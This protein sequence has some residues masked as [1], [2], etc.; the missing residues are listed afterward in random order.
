VIDRSEPGQP[1]AEIVNDAAK[2]IKAN[3]CKRAALL[4]STVSLCGR[5]NHPEKIYHGKRTGTC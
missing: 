1:A 5:G 4:A 3:N 2:M